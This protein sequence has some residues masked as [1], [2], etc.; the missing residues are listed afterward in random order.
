MC[1]QVVYLSKNKKE[2]EG[3]GENHMP[4][5]GGA[6]GRNEQK[7]SSSFS[8][9]RLQTTPASDEAS[10]G[11][12]GASRRLGSCWLGL[13]SPQGQSQAWNGFCVHKISLCKGTGGEMGQGQQGKYPI[14]AG[15]TVLSLGP[16]PQDYPSL[17]SGWVS[18][19]PRSFP[20]LFLSPALSR[21][22]VEGQVRPWGGHPLL[23]AT[24]SGDL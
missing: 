20:L 3:E 24:A 4:Q 16:S 22:S 21:Q 19:H 7:G 12:F 9:L 1:S 5:G 10:G 6:E 14:T 15:S 8:C 13:G 17:L 23:G 11:G 2:K 18:L